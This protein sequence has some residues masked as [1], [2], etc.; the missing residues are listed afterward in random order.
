MLWN[1]FISIITNNY[2]FYNLIK[3]LFFLKWFIIFINEKKKK[4][5]KFKFSFYLLKLLNVYLV[6]FFFK[7]FIS[8]LYKRNIL[9]FKKFLNEKRKKFNSFFNNNLIYVK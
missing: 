2:F 7:N 5:D 6:I 8:N 1:Y 3:K 4:N 9:D